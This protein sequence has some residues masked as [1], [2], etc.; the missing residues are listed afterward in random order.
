[1]FVEDKILLSSFED[2][3]PFWWFLNMFVVWSSQGDE[4][5]GCIISRWANTM[6][7]KREKK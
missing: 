2:L 7:R 4:C 1:L 5:L 6:N 3:S